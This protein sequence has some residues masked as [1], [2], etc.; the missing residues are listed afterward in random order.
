MKIK[1]INIEQFTKEFQKEYNF[2]YD[3]NDNVAG[4]REAVEFG[5]KFMTEH[6]DFVGEFTKYRGDLLT[7]DREV[8]AF[9]FALEKYL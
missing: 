4:Y 5:D 2:L 8:A 7:S 1:N 6:N 3:N 9:A